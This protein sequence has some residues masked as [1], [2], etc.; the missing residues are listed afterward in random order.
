MSDVSYLRGPVKK[1]RPAP[2]QRTVTR[3]PPEGTE[4]GVVDP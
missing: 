2:T 1:D 4:P 3:R